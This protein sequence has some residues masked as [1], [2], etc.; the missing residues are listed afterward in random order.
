MKSRKTKNLGLITVRYSYVME[1]KK[2]YDFKKGQ[3][4]L[5]ASAINLNTVYCTQ[6]NA[7]AG[8]S[9]NFATPHLKLP[10]ATHV[11]CL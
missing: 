6:K 3:S 8:F 1:D 2:Y 11:S 7:F 10:M 5:D 9:K 4:W